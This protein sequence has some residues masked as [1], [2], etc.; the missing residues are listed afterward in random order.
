M[1]VIHSDTM[2][3]MVVL[4]EMFAISRL[5]AILHLNRCG[6]AKVQGAPSKGLIYLLD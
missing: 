3:K 5:N 1:P 6:V 4:E 2:Q